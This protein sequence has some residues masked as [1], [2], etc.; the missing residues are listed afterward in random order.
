MSGICGSPFSFAGRAADAPAASLAGWQS[1]HA[2]ACKAVHAGSI[3]TPASTDLRAP[4]RVATRPI[5]V[6]AR[7]RASARAT[8]AYTMVALR[9]RASVGMMRDPRELAMTL[10]LRCVLLALV[11]CLLAT[12]AFGQ[13]DSTRRAAV[14]R[15]GPDNAFPQVARLPTATNLH[16]HGCLANRIWCDIQAGRTRG[17]VRLADLSHTSRLRNAATVTF[18][19][20]ELLGRALPH[21]GL[22]REPRALA[23]AGA[24]R[25]SCRPRRR[26]ADRRRGRANGVPSGARRCP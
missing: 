14:V 20:A 2:A 7:V 4:R 1:G 3:P 16:V 11:P 13:L 24:R 22:V 17:W 5:A 18:S 26:H 9:G 19:V 15:A 25:I 23:S 21:A 6:A 12:P 10:R 8:L